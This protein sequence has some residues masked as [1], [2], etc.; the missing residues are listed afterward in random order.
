[1]SSSPDVQVHIVHTSNYAVKAALADR[2][3]DELM[4]QCF[5]Q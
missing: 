2:Y 1:M 3:S 4:A 5:V